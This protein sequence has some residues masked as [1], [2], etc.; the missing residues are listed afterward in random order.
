[1][2]DILF[3]WTEVNGTVHRDQKVSLDLGT[4]SQLPLVIL[5]HGLGGDINDMST[6]AKRLPLNFNP[7]APVPTDVLD[8]GW[9]G[10]P[11]F[12]YWGFW[13]DPTMPVTGWQSSLKAFGY[14]TLNYMQI[15][16]AGLLANPTRQLDALVRAVAA[17]Q[18]GRRIAFV[19]HSRG[20]LLLRLFLQRNRGDVTLLQRIAGAVTL[21]SPHQGS[22]VA[23]LATNLN[24][25]LVALSVAF[26]G[27]V[28]IALAIVAT[29]VNSPGNW[30]L[31]TDSSLLAQLRAAE[32][33]PLPV[34]IPIHTFGGTNPRLRRVRG[35]QFDLMS[36]VPQWHWPPF[37][38]QTFPT[39]ILGV[40]SV[41]DGIP[42][43]AA[44]TP[45]G[46]MGVGD[47][48]GTDVRSHLPFEASHHSHP[49]NH[50]AALWHEDL[51]PEVHDI[52]RNL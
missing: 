20:G 43:L 22:A 12:G 39:G 33:T 48:L 18:P 5:L 23:D 21:H 4:S 35:H 44:L 1:M 29:F 3:T 14:P 10:Y 7:N 46:Q 15:E 16:P 24:V 47:V 2:T 38:W 25:V 42:P 11:N 28:T 27:L 45:E 40:F 13:G 31:R 17:N 41:L 49:I 8:R 32:A 37:H 34:R 50:A 51:K 6:P 9:Q 52:L 36:A 30:E 19:C 26:P